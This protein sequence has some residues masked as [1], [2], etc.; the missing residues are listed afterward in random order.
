MTYKSRQYSEK[1]EH[2]LIKAIVAQKKNYNNGQEM[3]RQ[4][5]IKEINAKYL[6]KGI[7]GNVSDVLNNID[8]W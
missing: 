7:E 6:L 2:K 4:L 1:D 5:K 3:K 8:L